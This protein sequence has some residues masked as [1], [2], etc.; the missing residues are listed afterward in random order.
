[1]ESICIP[2]S[3]ARTVL[4]VGQGM[5]NLAPSLAYASFDMTNAFGKARRASMLRGTAKWC[6]AHCRFLCNLWSARNVAWVE[7]E[8]G[9]WRA[10]DVVDGAFQGDTSR[11]P[12]FS[13][14][15]RLKVE[16]ICVAAAAKG[17]WIQPLSLV[18]DLL[19]AVDPSRVDDL[20][21]I[22]EEKVMAILGTEL[23]RSK[24]KV[25]IPESSENGADDH[26]GI[27]GDR[28]G[29]WRPSCTWICLCRRV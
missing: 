3:R 15:I 21:D 12:S 13:R 8:P 19:I 9:Q 1:M 11:T 26:P 25:F 17:M 7:H 16:E 20:V 4:M 18:D 29:S 5:M 24:C 23:N 2:P 6:K 10:V 28:A 14:A 27:F 22:V